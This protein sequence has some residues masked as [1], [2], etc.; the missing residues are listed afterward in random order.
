M[1]EEVRAAE[2]AKY[3]AIYATAQRYT[4]NERRMKQAMNALDEFMHHGWSLLDVGCGDGSFADAVR[5][6]YNCLATGVDPVPGL[7]R[8]TAS[9]HDLPFSDRT[10]DVVTF[11]DVLEHILPEDT[12]ATL[13]ELARIA[14]HHVILTVNNNPSCYRGP[15]DTELHINIKPYD[16]WEELFNQFF[17]SVT[18]LN[19]EGGNRI[20]RFDL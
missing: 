15:N 5:E 14:R 8:V 7:A 10:Y 17:P 6:K 12:E 3:E 20:F 2:I 9:S 11:L 18:R 16:E 13:R 4:M 1:T 19:N